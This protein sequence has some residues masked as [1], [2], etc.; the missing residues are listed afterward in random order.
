MD[1]VQELLTRKGL[2]DAKINITS[3]WRIDLEGDGTDEV[4]ISA[5]TDRK[6][7][8]QDS[9]VKRGDYSLVLL[10]KIINGKVVTIPIDLCYYTEDYT[11][12]Q[13]NASGKYPPIFSLCAVLDVN[14]D[15][16]MEILVKHYYMTDD[17]TV[18]QVDG[19]TVKAV[20]CAASDV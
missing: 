19:A 17:I 2:P 14:G 8:R 4:L 1:V 15:D 9:A 6:D 5:T 7:Y 20:L 13:M 11:Y 10:R 12:E 16:I 18:Y 3:I